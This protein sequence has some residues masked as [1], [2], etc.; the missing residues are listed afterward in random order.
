MC[1]DIICKKPWIYK[2]WFKKIDLSCPDKIY[3]GYKVV[4]HAS[5]FWKK[6]SNHKFRYIS[7]I[8]STL[9]PVGEWFCENE[10]TRI[11]ITNGIDYQAGFHL[12][13]YYSDAKKYK[14]MIKTRYPQYQLVI[15]PVL[16]KSVI[17]VGYEEVQVKRFG[18]YTESIRD[19]LTIVAKEIFIKG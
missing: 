5:G 15:I 17:L 18:I 8:I 13:F 10:K 14:E 16:F 1:I 9:L 11:K 4:G 6:I 7:P 2:R 19:C 12:F 3:T